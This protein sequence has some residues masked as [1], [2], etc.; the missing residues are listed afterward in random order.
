MENRLRFRTD[1]SNVI[2]PTYCRQHF[3][4]SGSQQFG[5][6]YLHPSK[7]N[8]VKFI[9]PSVKQILGQFNIKHGILLWP[10]DGKTTNFRLATPDYSKGQETN[11]GHSEYQL[12]TDNKLGQMVTDF[13][14]YYDCPEYVI[15]Y[16][17]NLPCVSPENPDNNKPRCAQMVVNAKEEVETICEDAWFYLYTTHETPSSLSD[18]KLLPQFKEHIRQKIAFLKRNGINWI[19][20]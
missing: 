18:P 10:D 6:V 8:D 11:Y 12:L 5:Y 2:P 13:K 9:H 20:P 4:F 1:L 7:S 3:D 16:S 19:H 17:S 15:L 14:K